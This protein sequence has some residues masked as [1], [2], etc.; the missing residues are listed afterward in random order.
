MAEE[1]LRLVFG[2]GVGVVAAPEERMRGGE[3]VGESGLV[4]A[5]GSL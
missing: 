4:G 5:A 2:E 1:G 3:T